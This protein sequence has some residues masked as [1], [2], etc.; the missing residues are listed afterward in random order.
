VGW[1]RRLG[2]RKGWA[3]RVAITSEGVGERWKG[4]V[5]QILRAGECGREKV[6]GN[7]EKDEGT[8]KR[9]QGVESLLF[10]LA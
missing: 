8:A 3:D 5:W 7:R 4:N 10:F 9:A 6:E 2:E 1:G